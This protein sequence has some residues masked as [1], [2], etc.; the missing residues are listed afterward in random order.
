MHLPSQIQT[1]NPSF[2]RTNM[3]KK[4]TIKG[5]KGNTYKAYR[6]CKLTSHQ[7]WERVIG[8]PLPRSR[9]QS[10]DISKLGFV[11]FWCFDV[12]HVIFVFF[13]FFNVFHSFSILFML[14]C[15]L[16]MCFLRFLV[17]QCSSPDTVL[18]QWPSRL[19]SCDAT[20]DWM[21][22]R[23]SSL[24]GCDVLVPD[25]G[26]HA[27]SCFVER[28]HPWLWQFLF[29][30]FLS[31]SI[32]IEFIGIGTSCIP[33]IPDNPSKAMQVYKHLDQL[34][35]LHCIGIMASWAWSWDAAWQA[36]STTSAEM[37]S[38]QLLPPLANWADHMQLRLLCLSLSLSQASQSNLA[39]SVMNRYELIKMI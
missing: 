22:N 1:A 39:L 26:S 5:Y 4:C 24:S 25:L 18:I 7:H 9:R 31:H 30:E 2:A 20:W 13:M 12:I 27:A 28:S 3:A 29:L 19:V 32:L 8:D 33:S 21:R 36:H 6:I 34:I 10:K 15:I 16:F 37:Q 35:A 38:G 11:G 17:L 14:C 23:R